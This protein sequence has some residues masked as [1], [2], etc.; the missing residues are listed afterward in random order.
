MRWIKSKANRWSDR[1]FLSV[2]GAA[3]VELAI[4]APV[5]VVLV[6]AIA[7]YGFLMGTSASLEGAA[8][9]GAEVAQVNP[10]VTA[11]RLK[12]LNIFPTGV[13]PTVASVCTCADNTWPT[14]TACPPTGANPCTTVINPFTSLADT[15]VF[16]YVKVTAPQTFSPPVPY[17]TFT[18][19]T[20]L[21]PQTT[22]RAQ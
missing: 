21:N 15:R 20:S 11:A 7:N 3:A 19:S 16:E 5:L 17:G 4:T 12:A 18:T 10:S 8:R 2:D 13:T 14:G 22:T 6:L 9:A 1:G